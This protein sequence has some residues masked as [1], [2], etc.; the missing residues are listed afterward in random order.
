MPGYLGKWEV[1]LPRLANQPENLQFSSQAPPA[2]GG[3]SRAWKPIQPG[4]MLKEVSS[5]WLHRL[6]PGFFL[7]GVVRRN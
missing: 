1:E 6:D 4:K 3:Q 5:Y 2:T 7:V